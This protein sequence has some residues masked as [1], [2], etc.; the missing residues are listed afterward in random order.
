MEILLPDYLRVTSMNSIYYQSELSIIFEAHNL[1]QQS[2]EL[3]KI[4]GEAD[5]IST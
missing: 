2:S 3:R 5:A 1:K 4:R